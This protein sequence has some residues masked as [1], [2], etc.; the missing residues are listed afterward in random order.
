MSQL[1]SPENVSIFPQLKIIQFTPA[2]FLYFLKSSYFSWTDHNEYSQQ[3]VES[4]ISRLIIY[5][6]MLIDNSQFFFSLTHSQSILNKDFSRDLKWLLSLSHVCYRL[7]STLSMLFK[8]TLAWVIHECN[9][10]T[11][12]QKNMWEG[13]KGMC[14]EMI[15]R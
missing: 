6:L 1:L 13:E 4:H 7:H 11:I 14:G 5:K 15:R 2:Q 10:G 9:W 12:L 8:R 3:T